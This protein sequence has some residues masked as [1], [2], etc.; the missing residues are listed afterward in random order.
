V[1]Q[2][3][4]SSLEDLGLEGLV[5]VAPWAGLEGGDSSQTWHWGS[6]TS[7]KLAFACHLTEQDS[8]PS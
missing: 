8:I 2:D 4:G 7:C 5:V 1:D 3:I 6:L